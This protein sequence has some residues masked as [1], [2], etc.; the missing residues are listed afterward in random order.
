LIKK[1][2]TLRDTNIRKRPHHPITTYPQHNPQQL[3]ESQFLPVQKAKK[4]RDLFKK[5]YSGQG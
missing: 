5:S 3:W 2:P 4:N 1:H